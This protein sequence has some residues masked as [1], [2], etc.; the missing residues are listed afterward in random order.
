MFNFQN[1]T[2][3]AKALEN[4]LFSYRVNECLEMIK[5]LTSSKEPEHRGLK[6]LITETNKRVLGDFNLWVMDNDLS[7]RELIKYIHYDGKDLVEV[8]RIGDSENGLYII[9]HVHDN[10]T[11]VKLEDSIIAEAAY[12]FLDKKAIESQS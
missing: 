4:P 12:K 9:N 1:F 11:E 6:E 10:G 3:L 7:N 5:T 2:E 8:M